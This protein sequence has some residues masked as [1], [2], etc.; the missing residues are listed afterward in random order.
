MG[1]TPCE[2]SKFS[3]KKWLEGHLLPCFRSKNV[4]LPV[5]RGLS[6]KHTKLKWQLCPKKLTRI[7]EWTHLMVVLEFCSKTLTPSCLASM[8]KW[9]WLLHL[10][11]ISHH[12]LH[13]AKKHIISNDHRPPC[14]SAE[15]VLLTRL[16][17]TRQSLT[18]QSLT[19]QSYQQQQHRLMQ[20]ARV[21][22]LNGPQIAAAA[23]SNW[24][25]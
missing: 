11:A 7:D 4:I 22:G 9:S 13:L 12:I 5:K 2:H 24:K 3:S 15:A 6:L 19:H 16:S 18:R 25:K 20:K 14:A 10:P 17:L 8:R 23:R 21:L 1:I